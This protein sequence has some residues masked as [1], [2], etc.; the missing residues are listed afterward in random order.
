MLVI[1]QNRDEIV[2]TKDI[3][4][5]E[6]CIWCVS[7]DTPLATYYDFEVRKRVRVGCENEIIKAN[8]L[9]DLAMKKVF[10]EADSK[11]KMPT[12]EEAISMWLE[13]QR[14]KNNGFQFF[15]IIKFKVEEEK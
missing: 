12:Q 1:N 4:K 6:N 15:E 14:I 13:N 11:I 5:V 9:V 2:E 10:E 3:Y 8:E 7:L